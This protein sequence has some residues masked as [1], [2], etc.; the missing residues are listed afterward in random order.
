MLATPIVKTETQKDGRS[1]NVE[2]TKEYIRL[3]VD[4]SERSVERKV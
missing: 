4:W 3:F 2:W 1:V